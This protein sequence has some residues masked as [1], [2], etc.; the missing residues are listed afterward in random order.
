MKYTII[1]NLCLIASCMFEIY[2]MLDFYRAFH[3]IRRCFQPKARFFMCYICFATINVIVNMKYNNKLNLIFAVMLYLSIVLILFTGNLWFRIVHC[4]I[5]IFIGGSSEMILWFLMQFP[6]NVPTDQAFENE[7]FM[8][9]TMFTGKLVYFILL[10]IARQF[11]KYSTEKL[12]LKLFVSYI[13]VPVATFG[14]MFTIPYIRGEGRGY[15]LI[16]LIL[17]IFYIF[18]VLGNVSLFY[19]FSRYSKFKEQQIVHEVNKTK[20][21]EKKKYHNTV[22]NISEKYQELFH[23]INHYLRQI[24]IYADNNQIE[25]IKQVLSDLEVEFIRGERE[26]ICTNGFLNSI[27]TDFKERALKEHVSIEFFVETGFR[28]E[29]MKESDLV[30][31]LGNLLDN[32]LEAAKQC[33]ERKINAVFFM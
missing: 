11:S 15:T 27:L 23:N 13:I 21:E 2:F 14:I 17:I 6:A 12:D 7:F 19:V 24:G 30:A 18:S 32:A 5:V 16:N 29:F 20:Y 33:K 22:E 26:I 1:Y 4:A 25:K 28:I 8:I 9:I 3:E 31:V 10:S